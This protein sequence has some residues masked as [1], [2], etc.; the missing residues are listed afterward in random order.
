MTLI[1]WPI[2]IFAYNRLA[3]RKEKD[4]ESKFSQ[5]FIENKRRFPAFIPRFREGVNS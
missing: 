1:I 5:K 2:L 4:V 3:M